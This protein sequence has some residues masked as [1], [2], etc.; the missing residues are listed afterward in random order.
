MTLPKQCQNYI[1]NTNKYQAGRSKLRLNWVFLWKWSGFTGLNPQ[2][3]YSKMNFIVKCVCCAPF[4]ALGLSI[5]RVKLHILLLSYLSSTQCKELCL[6]RRSPNSALQ[7]L[8]QL[9]HCHYP[10]RFSTL[11]EYQRLTSTTALTQH[12]EIEFR[13]LPIRLFLPSLWVKPTP[14][15]GKRCDKTGG[16]G[17]GK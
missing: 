15:R 4:R 16:K 7:L 14:L 5:P 11:W 12:A 1:S 6:S 2:S 8:V 13:M 3:S 9:P 10:A 17:S